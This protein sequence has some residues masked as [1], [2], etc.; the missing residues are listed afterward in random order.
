VY[1][2][3]MASFGDIEYEFY[4][5]EVQVGSKSERYYGKLP[6]DWKVPGK[7]FAGKTYR[8]VMQTREGRRYLQWWRDQPAYEFSDS[9]PEQKESNRDFKKKHVANIDACFKL[10]DEFLT[11]E[12][13]LRGKKRKVPVLANNHA[14][15]EIARVSSV[16]NSVVEGNHGVNPESPID[17]SKEPEQNEADYR[18]REKDVVEVEEPKKKRPAKKL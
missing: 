7:K 4:D 8:D 2:K 17:V 6:L 5:D 3:K 9:T 12:G 14:A 16:V 18:P 15:G 1:K 11:L 10:Y 13:N